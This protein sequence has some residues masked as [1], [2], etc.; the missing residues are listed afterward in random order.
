LFTARYALSP[1]IKHIR[2]VFEELMDLQSFKNK[3][4]RVAVDAPPQ[5]PAKGQ[6]GHP[7]NHA[8]CY[9]LPVL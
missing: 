3:K 4:C 2:F 7:Y 9:R 8:F 5:G 1:Y 6:L